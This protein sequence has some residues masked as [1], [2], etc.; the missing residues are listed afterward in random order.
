[1]SPLRIALLAVALAGCAGGGR[2]PARPPADALPAGSPLRSET[3]APGDAW[4]R[5]YLMAGH[6][7]SALRMLEAPRTAPRDALIRDL[8][9]GLVLHQLGRWAESNAAFQAAEDEAERRMT[10]SVSQQAGMLLVND[11]MAAYAPPPAEM[12]MVPYYRMLNYLALGGGDGPLVE[13]R[14]ANAYL[15]RLR[16]GSAEPCVGEGF[17]QYLTGLVYAG[18]GE[19]SDALVSFRQ[20]ERAYDACGRDPADA[21]DALGADLFRAARA[22]GVREVADS[23]A[24]RY[25]LSADPAPSRG[26]ELVVVVEEGWVAHRAPADIHVPIPEGEVENLQSGD[27]GRVTGATARVAAHLLANLA[28]QGRWGSTVD[29]RFQVADALGGAHIVK[30]AWAVPA[31]EASA[32]ASVQ[33]LLEG[34]TAAAPAPAADVSGAVVRRWEAQR[35]AV[36]ARMVARG[37][38]KYLAARE[39]E[40][41][42]AKKDEALGWLAARMANLAGNALERADT[43]S[44]SL[45]PDR[46]SVARLT[47]PAGEHHVRLRVR[48][49]GGAEEEVDLGRVSLGPGATRIVHRRV[50]GAGRGDAARLARLPAAPVAT[51]D[52]IAPL[53]PPMPVA[54]RAREKAA[55]ADEPAR[56]DARR[57]AEPAVA[58]PRLRAPP[59]IRVPTAPGGRTPAVARPPAPR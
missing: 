21:P 54:E 37:V 10:R 4:L 39:A 33:V 6:P 55:D 57:P 43:R 8:Q 26:A 59:A 25:R 14:K 48:G 18:A 7:D 19:R 13:A 50:W 29:E 45:L 47:L 3:L 51:A 15:E 20:A 31:L 5:H 41:R 22:A 2:F 58:P 17:V 46:I 23:A 34:D 27:A 1:M 16:R 12:A 40:E 53:L 44:W 9:R 36:V 24:A 38:L 52:E 32:P 35:P 42:G 28:E 49:A 30:M 11:A 56:R